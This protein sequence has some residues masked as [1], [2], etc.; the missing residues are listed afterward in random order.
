MIIYVAE[1]LAV[2]LAIAAIAVTRVRDLF[3]L[4]VLLSVYSGLLAAILAVMGAPDV[5]FTEA[6]VGTS[7]STIFF[8]ALMWWINPLELSRYSRPRR[9]IAW[10][11]AFALGALLL[12]GVNALPAFGDADSPPM[13]YVSPD[14][15][16]GSI[17]DMATPNVVTAV[18]AD[19]RALDTL[20]ETAVVLTAA[21][22]VLLVLQRRDDPSV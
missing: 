14:Y 8:M 12:Y 19:Y 21:L 7:V 3:A 15:V 1:F 4:V 16:A 6:V 13:V 11:P 18:L 22:A 5:A 2:L 17:P 9:L 10:I 20:I